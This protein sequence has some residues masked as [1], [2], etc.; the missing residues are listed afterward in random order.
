MIIKENL[1][2]L[3]CPLCNNYTS[4]YTHYDT[5]F[6][7]LR[8]GSKNNTLFFP[9]HKC[10]ITNINHAIYA[11]YS[12]NKLVELNVRV[13]ACK[14][15]NC[16]K[17]AT[18]ITF[19]PPTSYY[20]ELNNDYHFYENNDFNLELTIPSIIQFHETMKAFQ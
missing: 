8:F 6:P 11:Y 20:I 19:C 10:P 3:Q 7:L 18:Y 17:S 2:D 14:K 15:C 9:I 4:N 13:W 5:N 1:I 16:S 12:H